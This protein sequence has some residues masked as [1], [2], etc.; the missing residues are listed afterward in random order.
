MIGELTGT[1]R[2]E[3]TLTTGAPANGGSCVA[4]HEGRVVFVRYALP[5]ERV[6]VRVTADRGSYWHAET[7]EVIDPSADRV[8]SLCPI[9]GS[10]APGVAIWRSPARRR[11]ATSRDAWSATSWPA[12]VATAG[13]AK[14]N[15]SA[16]PVRPVGEPGCGSTWGMT[17]GPVFIATT[18]TNW[19]PTCA[20]GSYRPG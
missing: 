1:P 14:P 12:W 6:R 7:V 16:R 3:L 8:P 9:A 11:R 17:G 4:R 20:A 15:P 18:A 19:S 10:R 5:G 13:T 2:S